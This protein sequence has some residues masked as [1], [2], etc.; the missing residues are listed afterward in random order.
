[1]EISFPSQRL[2]H[3]SFLF[4][5]ACIQKSPDTQSL[6]PLALRNLSSQAHR[7][8]LAPLLKRPFEPLRER[9]LLEWTEALVGLK[10]LH[11]GGKAREGGGE[12]GREGVRA[13][14]EQGGLTASPLP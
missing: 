11:Q 9:G 6:T 12:E 8:L 3:H 7:L 1:M 10:Q 5:G 14:K 2:S 4:V 13:G